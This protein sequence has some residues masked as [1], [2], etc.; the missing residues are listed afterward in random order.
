MDDAQGAA[1]AETP[2]FHTE[3]NRR[4]HAF[5]AEQAERMIADHGC[6]RGAALVAIDG[7]GYVSVASF[8]LSKTGTDILLADALELSRRQAPVVDT[9]PPDVAPPAA[10]PPGPPVAP[11][12][13]DPLRWI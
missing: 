2:D 1:P 11:N 8:A 6:I 9:T 5:V 3:I 7:N 12:P 13:N 10:P 4:F